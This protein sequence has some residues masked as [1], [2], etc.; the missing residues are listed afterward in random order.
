VTATGQQGT[1]GGKLMTARGKQMTAGGDT[2]GHWTHHI[3]AKRSET[4]SAREIE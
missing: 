1:A 3:L 2:Q 4:Q